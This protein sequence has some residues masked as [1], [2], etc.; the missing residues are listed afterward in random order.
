LRADAEHR[1]RDLALLHE[2]GVGADQEQV[3]AREFDAILAEAVPAWLQRWRRQLGRGTGS[4][5]WHGTRAEARG[6]LNG[7]VTPDR[8]QPRVTQECG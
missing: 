7:H 5:S 3:P 1:L 6:K 8:R 4:W 2:S